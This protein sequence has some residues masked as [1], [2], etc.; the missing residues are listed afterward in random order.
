MSH[1]PSQ[2]L[3]LG[4]TFSMFLKKGHQ[5]NHINPIWNLGLVTTFPI[6]FKKVTR[7]I[8][9]TLSQN[10]GLGTTFLMLL[11]KGH[12]KNPK[13]QS[14]NLGLVT[15]KRISKNLWKSMNDHG[16]PIFPK[17]PWEIWEV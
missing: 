11:E 12:Q 8:V 9:K 14:Q 2:N 13:N 5:K 7:K 10:L 17:V 6:L 3:G 1:L 4:T 15:T 16:F